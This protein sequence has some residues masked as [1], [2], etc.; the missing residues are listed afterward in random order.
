MMSVQRPPPASVRLSEAPTLHPSVHVSDSVLGTWTELAAEVVFT[1]S[2]LGDYSYIMERGQVDHSVIGKFCS[3]ASDV[4]LNP[5][6]HPIERASS[7]H[8]TYRSAA[9]GL[10]Q[11]DRAFFERRASQ[12]L[13]IGHD[14]WIGHGATVM[15]GVRIGHGAVI[16][17][18]AV[19]TQDVRPYS[20]VA[21]VPARMIR[22]RF[23]TSVAEG[24]IHLA[25]WDWTHAQLGERLGDLRG[26]PRALTAKYSLTES[27]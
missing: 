24:L 17:A 21:G 2:E 16:G 25:W 7:H 5:G 11:D 20:V 27:L 9:Y 15:G 4:R 3:I 23:S 13:V 6:Q 12:Q 18:G 19:V 22:A 10:G 1:A 14:V 8:L 26:D